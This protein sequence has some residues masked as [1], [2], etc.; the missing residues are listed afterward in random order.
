MRSTLDRFQVT[1]CYL[2][3]EP[4]LRLEPSIS[5]SV[6]WQLL[7]VFIITGGFQKKWSTWVKTNRSKQGSFSVF[8]EYDSIAFRKNIGCPSFKAQRKLI[9]CIEK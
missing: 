6:E 1:G 5:R 8:G 4:L 7:S 3:G 2:K 9:K